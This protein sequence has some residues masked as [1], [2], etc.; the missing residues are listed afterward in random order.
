MKFIF[1]KYWEII[2]IY[3][4]FILIWKYSFLNNF[5]LIDDHEILFYHYKFVGLNFFEFISNSI[6]FT[7]LAD[8]SDSGRF[9]PSYYFMRL[10]EI[11]FYEDNNRIWYF[12]RLVIYSY[13]LFS[14]FLML[15]KKFSSIMTFLCLL[16]IVTNQNLMDIIPRLGTS[17]HYII[18]GLGFI[19][20]GLLLIKKKKLSSLLI[21]IGV[22]LSAGSKE[23]YIVFIIIPVIQLFFYYKRHELKSLIIPIIFSLISIFYSCFI[24]YELLTRIDIFDGR[25]VYG[26]KLNIKS[27][28]GLIKKLILSFYFHAILFLIF[29]SI[30]IIKKSENKYKKEHYMYAFLLTSFIFLTYFFYQGLSLGPSRYNFIVELFLIFY[31]FL[32][33]KLIKKIIHPQYSKIFIPSLI[34]ISFFLSIIHLE[35]ISIKT[36]KTHE[37]TNRLFNSINNL[38]F[39]MKKYN[40]EYL[41]LNSHSWLDYEA[42]LAINKMLLI[43]GFNKKIVLRLNDY[44]E[45]NFSSQSLKFRLAA[46]LNSWSKNGMKSDK[47]LFYP[48]NEDIS[49]NCYSLGIGGNSFKKCKN[50]NSI[51]W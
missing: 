39:N 4:I 18:L 27:Y 38:D 12:S 26:G 6:Q 25:N 32:I 1:K 24:L 30:F 11:F 31:L 5:S 34:I 29:I 8:H 35:K 20:N 45:T 15:K 3:F 10:T 42:V 47:N 22:I 19:F 43:K 33:I 16:I 28:L 14:L 37:Q 9:R 46:A 21:N 40:T 51:I 48:Y 41:V 7:E 50:E 44:S 49:K 36:K 23:L 2:F 17:E 13:F